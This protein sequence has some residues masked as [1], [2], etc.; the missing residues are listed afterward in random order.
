MTEVVEV[1]E[2]EVKGNARPN[3]RALWIALAVAFAPAM[4]SAVVVTGI[5]SHNVLTHGD[6]TPAPRAE[7]NEEFD[8][9][10]ADAAIEAS[11]LDQQTI[12][13]PTLSTDRVT[14]PSHTTL[15]A[16]VSMT[17]DD[18]CHAVGGIV[19]T[20]SPPQCSVGIPNVLGVTR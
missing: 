6:V 15:P 1:N 11:Q 14:I 13:M 20:V 3:R 2:T 5:V 4:V 18:L 17:G 12:P 16:I 7:S 19:L 9:M 8:N 10:I